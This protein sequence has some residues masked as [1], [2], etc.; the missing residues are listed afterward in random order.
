MSSVHE[1]VNKQYVL[2]GFIFAVCDYGIDVYWLNR[3]GFLFTIGKW[4]IAFSRFFVAL[5]VYK[6]L[7]RLRVGKTYKR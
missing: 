2:L 6:G 3:S 4:H 1:Q 7:P 5:N